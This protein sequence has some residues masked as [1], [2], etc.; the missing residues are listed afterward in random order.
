MK[1]LVS[2][3]VV[4]GFLVA[5]GMALSF[6]IFVA[7]VEL[8]PEDVDPKNIEYVLWTHGMNQNM[9]LEHAIAGMTHD[10]QPERLVRG[11]TKEQLIRRFGYLH[12]ADEVPQFSGCHP[13]VGLLGI[14]T[15]GKDV[16]FLRD[17]PWMAIL[18][19]GKAVDLALCKGY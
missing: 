16:I 17:G 19:D 10:K 8:Y 2:K 15:Q 5:L 13:F 1:H 7:W 14:S 18:D 9:N 6:A 12:R 11:L 4:A 3:T